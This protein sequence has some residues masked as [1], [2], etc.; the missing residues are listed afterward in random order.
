MSE[1]N[2]IANKYRQQL[3]YLSNQKQQLEVQLNVLKNTIEE[4]NKTSEKKVYKGIGNIFIKADKDKV[5]EENKD[6]QET[7][8]LR[9]KNVQK[10]EDT[11][12]KK[13]NELTDSNSKTNE[14]NSNNAEGIS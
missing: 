4:L 3:M 10:Q 6:L 5:I 2:S 13:L 11:L 12:I 7:V 1:S 8:S 14:D 9:I